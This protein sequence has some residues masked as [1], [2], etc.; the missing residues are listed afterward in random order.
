[1]LLRSR[2]LMA[3]AA[4]ATVLP[5]APPAAADGPMPIAGFTPAHAKWQRQYEKAF[6]AVPSA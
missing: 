6:G 2:V 1:M 4:V 3:T 5:I